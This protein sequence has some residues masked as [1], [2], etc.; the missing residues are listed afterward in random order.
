MASLGADQQKKLY[1]LLG[2]AGLLGIGLI[3]AFHPFGRSTTSTDA[4]D[5]STPAV[6]T[7]AGGA[8]GG[9]K[10]A[11]PAAAGSGSG[12]TIP[13]SS[14]GGTT[15]TTAGAGVVPLAKPNTQLISTERFRDD[16]FIP[17]IIPPTPAPPPLPT[18][19]PIP[20]AVPVPV[21]GGI[22]VPPADIRGAVSS[23][24]LSH[25]PILINLPPV[26]ISRMNTPPINPDTAVP[27]TRPGATTAV[28]PRSP[29]KRVSGVVIGNTVRALIEISDGDQVVTRVVQ[30]GDEVEGIKILRIERVREG[31]RNVTRMIVREENEERVVELKASPNPIGGGEGG[32]GYPGGGSGGGYPGGGSSSIGGYPGGGSSSIGGRRGGIVP[33]PPGFGSAD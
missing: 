13:V 14:G 6:T 10:A 29:N 26:R 15:P 23:G 28:L 7:K 20:P 1:I 3:I 9:G 33:R 31:D 16:P 22:E 12:G 8:T 24:A 32:S 18:P 25:S 17:E 21:P 4:G 11:S 30:P 2:L 5:T 27:Q 19:T